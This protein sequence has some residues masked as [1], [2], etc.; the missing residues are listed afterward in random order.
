MF[1]ESQK[2]GTPPSWPE[3]LETA[4]SAAIE[5]L[6]NRFGDKLL[7]AVRS[8]GADEDS[9]EHAFAGIFESILNVP[10]NLSDVKQ[11]II[12]CWDSARLVRWVFPRIL[13]K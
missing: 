7:L 8:S 11:A 10:S 2:E 9:P 13:H 4:L 1:I 12:K 5:K 3:E 6:Q